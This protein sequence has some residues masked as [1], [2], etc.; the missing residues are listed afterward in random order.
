MGIQRTNQ[1]MEN[2]WMACVSL[3]NT[4]RLKEPIRNTWGH[5][6]PIRNTWGS[7]ESIWNIWRLREPIRNTGNPRKEKE[8][9][10][11]MLVDDPENPLRTLENAYES[12]KPK[13]NT[14]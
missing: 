11:G 7:R 2:Q 6:E 3:G 8:G 13:W 9:S 4:W 14:W 12:G 1:K 10:Q 5:R